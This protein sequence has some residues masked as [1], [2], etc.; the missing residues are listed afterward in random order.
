MRF[1]LLHLPM[2]NTFQPHL[3]YFEFDLRLTL[4]SSFTIIW[5]QR[6]HEC[7]HYKENTHIEI[8]LLYRLFGEKL[9][10]RVTMA[11]L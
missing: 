7:Y 10:T 8:S 6:S 4:I 1:D 2:S 5:L 3:L 11:Y 9:Y